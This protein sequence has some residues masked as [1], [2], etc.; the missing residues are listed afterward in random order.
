MNNPPITITFLGTGT[1]SGVPM[2][3]CNC[4]VCTSKN[5]KDTRL[6]SSILVQSD[7]TT[8]VID[9]TPDF[10]YQM[11]RIQNKKLDAVLFTHPHRDHIGG[12]DDIRPYNYFQGTPIDVYANA[13]TEKYLRKEFYYVF[14]E[15]KYPGLPD[16]ALHTID[17]TPFKIGDIE[18][19]P[20][21]VWHLKMPVYGF[22]IGNFTYITDAN[23][24]DDS[25]KEKIKGSEIL[26]LNTLRK[27]K[28]LSH[29]TLGE[30]VALSQE[31]GIK[32]TFFTHISHQLGLNDAINNELPEGICLAYDGLTIK[33]K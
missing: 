13:L 16:V 33:M 24:I 1:S 14:E 11:L 18:I 25:E 29:F 6:R 3:A 15:N 26:V 28:H 32:E 19:I 7:K 23:R 10:R 4:E 2:I 17:E 27:E 5:P 20:I 9:T 8:F 22:R 30:G 21:L 31:L 12:L